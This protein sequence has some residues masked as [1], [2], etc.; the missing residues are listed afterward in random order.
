MGERLHPDMIESY[1][2]PVPG[3]TTQVLYSGREAC[4][5]DNLIESYRG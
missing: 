3:L 2:R 1:S 4:L 5:A